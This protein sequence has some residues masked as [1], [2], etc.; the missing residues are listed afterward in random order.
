[1][2]QRERAFNV[3]GVIL[4]LVV[5]MGLIHAVRTYV[6]S[7]DADFDLLALLAFTPGRLTAHFDAS[8]VASVMRALALRGRGE[9]EYAEFFFGDGSVQ[10]WTVLTYAF[11]HADW[12]HYGLNSIWLVAFGA[13][14]ARRFGTVRFLALFVVTAV[15]GVAAHYALHAHDPMPIIGASAAVSGAM[16]ASLRFVFQPG[17]PLGNALALNPDDP[18]AYRLPALSLQETLRDRRVLTFILFWFLTNLAFG[19]AGQPL[20]LVE[21]GVAWEAHVGGFLCGLLLFAL[22]DPRASEVVREI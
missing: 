19:L 7:I 16:G 8:G 13:P 2:S 10:P 5:C 12:M 6:L 21:G 3:P 9:I 1:M 18:R 4:G 15:A 14:V 11:L 22:F 17:A 20:G